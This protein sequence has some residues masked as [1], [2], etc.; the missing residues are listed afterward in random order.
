MEEKQYNI[1]E[2]NVKMEEE[3][4][5]RLEEMGFKE[6]L[7]LQEGEN[8]LYIDLE[9]PVKEVNTIYGDKYVFSLQN[10]EEHILMASKYLGRLLVSALS[11]ATTGKA[12]II[13]FI[14]GGKVKYK[15]TAE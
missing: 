15:V 9:Q 3:R 14:D 13:K 1:N 8:I 6:P 10:D 11:T 5:Q 2:L 12:T 7:R 4:K